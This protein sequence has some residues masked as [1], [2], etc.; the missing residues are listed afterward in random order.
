MQG[1]YMKGVPGTEH[2][3]KHSKGYE[4]FKQ[5]NGKWTYL[6]RGKTLIIAL[7]KR[8]WCQA[9]NWERYPSNFKYIKKTPNGNFI[10]TKRTNRKIESYGTFKTLKEAQKEVEVLKKYDWDLEDVCDLNE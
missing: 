5:L 6:G 1:D 7:M 10:I 9:N 3:K 8:D 2:I 4:I